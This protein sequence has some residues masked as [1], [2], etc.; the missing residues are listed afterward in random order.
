MADSEIT[1]PDE[2]TVLTE[3][4]NRLRTEN[5]QLTAALENEK[6]LVTT[7]QRRFQKELDQG[8][9]QEYRMVQL[10]KEV[11]KLNMQLQAANPPPASMPHPKNGVSAAAL[12]PTTPPGFKLPPPPKARRKKAGEPQVATEGAHLNGASAEAE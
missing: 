6:M 10:E 4:R 11:E 5:S 12:A 2:L 7:W 1:P 9:N 3:E 8:T